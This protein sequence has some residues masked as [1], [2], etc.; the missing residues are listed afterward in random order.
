[1]GVSKTSLKRLVE[2]LIIINNNYKTNTRRFP[3]LIEGFRKKEERYLID[4]GLAD[5]IDN[6]LT[7]YY[8]N[9]DDEVVLALDSIINMLTS[10]HEV[11]LQHD[12]IVDYLLNVIST[13][14]LESARQIKKATFDVNVDDDDEW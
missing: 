6:I 10:L 9:K 3:A 7:L 13:N 11:Y 8:N 12:G 5:V 4:L 1:M 2:E 14:N